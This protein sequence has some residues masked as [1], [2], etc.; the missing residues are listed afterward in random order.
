MI[1]ASEN[2]HPRFLACPF[3]TILSGIFGFG[4]ITA[5]C[6]KHYPSHSVADTN[7]A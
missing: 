1:G 2:S 3:L 7:F 5:L 6:V 4:Y